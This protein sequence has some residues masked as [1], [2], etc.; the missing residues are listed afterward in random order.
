MK[1]GFTLVEIMVVVVIMGVLAAVG[2]P[3]LF[4]VIAKA[5]AAEVPVAAGS[6]IGL[7]NAY[8]HENNGIGSWK[9]IGYG[10]PGGGQSDYFDYSGCING[11]IRFD[12]MEPDMPGWQA[13]SRVNLNSCKTGSAWV[14]VIDPTGEN[15]VTYRQMVSSADCAALAGNWNIGRA[16]EGKCEAV[17]EL[18]EAGTE[19]IEPKPTT[20]EPE[21]TPSEPE[22]STPSNNQQTEDPNS[23]ESPVDCEALAASKHSSDPRTVNGNKC[24][25]CYVQACRLAVN[26]GHLPEEINECVRLCDYEETHDVNKEIEEYEEEQRRKEQEQQEAQNQN[27]EQ[28]QDQ[29]QNQS[30]NS[31]GGKGYIG[32]GGEQ[33]PF[34]ESTDICLVTGEN[35]CEEWDDK[36]EYEGCTGTGCP[37][38]YDAEN[39][40]C[41]EVGDGDKCKKWEDN[42]EYKGYSGAG[43]PHKYDKSI[44]YCLESSENTCTSWRPK[45]ECKDPKNG[46]C[47]QWKN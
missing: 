6:Y 11:T 20:N 30:Q 18:H 37:H 9:N 41:L 3:K 29:N 23:E 5:K 28:N 31:S 38:K 47:K 8:L 32:G 13:T 15:D 19:N 43:T 36:E 12:Q 27:Q 44:D 10:A 33:R 39:D 40:V 17:G 16:V 25:W 46:W 35:G 26:N 21:N 42:T 1:K 22:A 45:S 2:V 24:G 7:Q 34:N 4:G 14:V